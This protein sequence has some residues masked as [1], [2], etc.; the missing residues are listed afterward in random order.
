MTVFQN[1]KNGITVWSSNSISEYRPKRMGSRVS[2]HYPYI[3]IHSSTIH[4][5]NLEAIQV[6]I[7][8]RMDKQIAVYK[9][10]IVCS[11]K[12]GKELCNTGFNMNGRWGHC[13]KWNK[14]GTKSQVLNNLTYMRQVDRKWNVLPTG[15]GKEGMGSYHWM[16]YRVST[17]QEKELQRWVVVMTVQ[18]KYT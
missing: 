9:D 12:K 6:S 7:S 11:L 17:S 18:H 2:K 16:N 8:E 13:T 4:N 15:W 10:R 3:H 1:I 5:W 14:P